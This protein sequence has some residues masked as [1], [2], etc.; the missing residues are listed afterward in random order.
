M[1]IAM[2]LKLYTSAPPSGRCAIL[3]KCLRLVSL[4][5]PQWCIEAGQRLFDGQ[6][7][8]ENPLVVPIAAPE[9][10]ADLEATCREYGITV[11]TEQ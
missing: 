8:A 6:H 10:L 7:P 5:D 1:R 3:V 9:N 11:L 4:A 2:R